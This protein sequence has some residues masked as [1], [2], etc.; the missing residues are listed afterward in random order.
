MSDQQSRIAELL[1]QSDR[2]IHSGRYSAADEILQQILDADPGNDNARKYQ[3]RI[4]YLVKQLSQRSDLTKDARDEI[5]KY[6]Q[7]LASRKVAES[8]ALLNTARASIEQGDIRKAS[9]DIV[10]ALALDPGNSYAKALMQLLTDMQ[11]KRAASPDD[12]DSIFCYRSFVWET[13]HLGNPSEAQLGIL[14]GVQKQLAIGDDAAKRVE[15]ES[16][17]R[18]YKDALAAIWRSGG[19]AAFSLR[20]VEELQRKFGIPAIDHPAGAP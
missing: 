11:K 8:R 13:W 14:K 3:E 17:N 4:Q 9:F 20:E 12:P 1:L 10:R 15:R 2:L 18:L 7:L 6:S 19:I 5:R 16:R